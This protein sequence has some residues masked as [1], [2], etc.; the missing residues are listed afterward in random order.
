MRAAVALAL[1]ILQPAPSRGLA[2]SRSSV[3]PHCWVS[4][5][6]AGGVLV[7]AGPLSEICYWRSQSE[8]LSHISSQLSSEGV[9]ALTAVL[10]T[11]ASAYLAP[12]LSLRDSI[13]A[14]ATLAAENRRLLTCL[15]DSCKQLQECTPK[16][17]SQHYQRY[18]QTT[19]P[20]S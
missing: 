2:V 7:V 3:A 8:D 6:R 5:F 15:E 14:Q 19:A 12:F 13:M 20:Q 1:A 16:V 18:F 9:T 17:T 11:A 10:Q 4:P